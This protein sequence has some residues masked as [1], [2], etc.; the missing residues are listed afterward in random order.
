MGLSPSSLKRL[1]VFS[2]FSPHLGSHI[3]FYVY[4]CLL[5]CKCAVG[6]QC[7]QRPEVGTR[8]F[9][10]RVRMV[11]TYHGCFDIRT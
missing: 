10:T 7:Q 5:A 9:G 2:L 8:S 1:L 4:E 3:L 11:V 6:A